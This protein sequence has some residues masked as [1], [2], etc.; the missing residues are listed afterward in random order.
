MLKLS[1]NNILIIR[2]F[3][4]TI[5]AIAVYFPDELFLPKYRSG[6]GKVWGGGGNWLREEG[7]GS[8]RVT[9]SEKCKR[10]VLEGGG[11]EIRLSLLCYC[12]S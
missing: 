4:L 10:E 12:Y 1:Y 3:F 6:V 2:K 7:R 11:G 9:G 5:T 8:L